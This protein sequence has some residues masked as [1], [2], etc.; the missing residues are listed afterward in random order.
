MRREER[1]GVC[2]MFEGMVVFACICESVTITYIG[3]SSR[4]TVNSETFHGALLSA[5]SSVCRF[6]YSQWHR[7][8]VDEIRTCVRCPQSVMHEMRCH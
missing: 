3:C 8:G 4:R 2:E 6:M 1:D 7:T 5:S